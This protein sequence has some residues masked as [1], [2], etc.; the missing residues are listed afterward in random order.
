MLQIVFGG[1]S[2]NSS[3]FSRY[4]QLKLLIDMPPVEI[5]Y[6]MFFTWQLEYFERGVLKY[7]KTLTCFPC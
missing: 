7:L 2:Q 1:E 5:I 4:G 3:L 6:R